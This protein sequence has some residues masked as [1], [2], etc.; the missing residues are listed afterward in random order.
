MQQPGHWPNRLD[1]TFSIWFEMRN[2]PL[3]TSP[4]TSRSRD[5][6]SV[7]TFEFWPTRSWST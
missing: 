5:R 2:G 6:R 1:G 4:N 3:P 7:S